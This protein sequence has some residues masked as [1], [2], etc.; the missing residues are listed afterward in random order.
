MPPVPV[1][2]AV[3]LVAAA[4]AAQ[5]PTVPR[6]AE[7][8]EIGSWLLACSADPITDR[9]DCILRHRLWIVPPERGEG[10]GI[11]LEI[12]RREERVL[13]AV[14]ARG[15]T[16]ADTGRGAL[17]FAAAAE[18]RL[19]QDAALDL[20][21]TLEGRDAVCLPAGEAASRAAEALAR[22]R[23][24][25][26]RLRTAARLGGGGGEVYALDLAE[27]AAAIA[28]LR[29]RGPGAPPPPSPVAGFL[30]QLERLIRGQ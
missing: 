12:V 21:C 26:V 20:P 10:P 5:A 23:R 27:T 22:A 25:L 13:P 3:L 17:A 11:A 28:A 18:L 1:I 29:E 6:V 4:A 15:L 30:E 9:T 24:A 16:L 2:L 19:D 14:T 8:R 7:T